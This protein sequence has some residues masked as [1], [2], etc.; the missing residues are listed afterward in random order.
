LAAHL[1]T[2]SSFE[3]CFQ[4]MWWHCYTLFVICDRRLDCCDLDGLHSDDHHVDRC[5][6]PDDCQWVVF[7]PSYL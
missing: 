2:C 4:W 5:R 3:F 7:I 1:L 6:L